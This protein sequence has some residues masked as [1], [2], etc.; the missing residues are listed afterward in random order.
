MSY[1]NNLEI[2]NNR[3]EFPCKIWENRFTGKGFHI[4]KVCDV[5]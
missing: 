5:A 3:N 2:T 1:F 4:E